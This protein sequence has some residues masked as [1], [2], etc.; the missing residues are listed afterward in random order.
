MKFLGA[1]DKYWN[2]HV[3]R[4]PLESERPAPPGP[5]ETD[6]LVF[7]KIGAATTRHIDSIH[8][9]LKAKRKRTQYRGIIVA[10]GALSLVG[11]VWGISHIGD[12]FGNLQSQDTAPQPPPLPETV[13]TSRAS[14]D[15]TSQ[16]GEAVGRPMPAQIAVTVEGGRTIRVAG[17]AGS[18]LG[19][20][21][22][23]VP[24][25]R[26]LGGTVIREYSLGG[27]D[28]VYQ[29]ADQFTVALGTDLTVV[30]A[31][32]GTSRAGTSR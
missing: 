9:N 15:C 29:V 22:S 8:D 20:T 11:I 27:S 17:N 4:K 23:D 10:G 14:I 28:Q 16:P 3:P 1:L 12:V 26:M 24:S 2:Y 32:N 31:I 6:H 30:C 19:V 18:E 5:M 25:E 13:S 21:P 7:Q